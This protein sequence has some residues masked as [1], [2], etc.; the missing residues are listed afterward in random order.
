MADP[1]SN[2]WLGPALTAIGSFATAMIGYIAMRF[3]DAKKDERAYQR[4]KAARDDARRDKQR[5]RRN[6]FQRATLLEL[7]DMAIRHMQN[8]SKL[9]A[10]DRKNL[11]EHGERFVEPY[12]AELDQAT[13]LSGATVSKLRV[14]VSDDEARSLID[15]ITAAAA[16]SIF[17]TDDEFREMDTNITFAFDRFNKR[18]GVL[19]RTMDEQ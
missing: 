3:L 12:P 5:E 19:L 8:L 10:I 6:D 13:M 1:Q 16:S 2:T 17:M 18:V 9:H 7:Q 11:R 4:E 14:R 15:Q